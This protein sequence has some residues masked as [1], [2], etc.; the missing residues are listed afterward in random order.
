MGTLPEELTK[1]L[2][3]SYYHSSGPQMSIIC[4]LDQAKESFQK[5]LLNIMG[6]HKG[7]R[8]KEA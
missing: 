4:I 7:S 3:S 6:K 1:Y 8:I 2:K 5:V